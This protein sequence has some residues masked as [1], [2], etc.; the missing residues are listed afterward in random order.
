ML[1]LL[2]HQRSLICRAACFGSPERAQSATRQYRLSYRGAWSGQHHLASSSPGYTTTNDAVR[3]PPKRY[4][5]IFD[6]LGFELCNNRYEGWGTWYWG[7]FEASSSCFPLPT[8][9]MLLAAAVIRDSPAKGA[10]GWKPSCVGS[11]HRRGARRG[12]VSTSPRDTGRTRAC[13]V[14]APPSRERSA[15]RCQRA[16]HRRQSPSP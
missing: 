4:N 8:A 12:L 1:I 2:V 14:S 7:T 11:A 5:C 15:D 13:P 16:P 3:P 9:T 10:W 6:P